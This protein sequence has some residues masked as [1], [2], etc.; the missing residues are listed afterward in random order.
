VDDGPL[1]LIKQGPADF[2]DVGSI[3]VE[4]PDLPANAAII[5]Y[6]AQL[7]DEHG[8]ASPLVQIDECIEISMPLP[9]PLLAP[10]EPAGTEAA[11]RMTVRWFCPPYG[12]DRF[13]VSIANTLGLLGAE[14]SPDL[15]TQLTNRVKQF[16]VNGTAKTN[17]FFLYRT[18]R[19]GPAFGNGAQF[20]ITVNIALGQKYTVMVAAVGQDGAV[21]DD[22]NAES[23]SWHVPPLVG[24]DVPWPARPLP[25][26]NFF[27]A[28]LQAFRMPDNIFPG[29]ALRI[30]DVPQ[31]R[32]ARAP[33]ERTDA[34]PALLR[35]HRDPLAY[36]YTN[37]LG[38]PL[39]PAVVYRVQ[40]A[41]AE[42]PQVSRDLNQ[43]TPLME[44]IAHEF[45]A[46]GQFGD[47]TVIHDP[48]IRVTEGVTLGG[49]ALPGALWLVDTQPVIA[50]ARYLYLIARL[51]PDGEILEVIP[52]NV[53]EATP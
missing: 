21:G 45:S 11:P 38:D 41:A 18:P 47:V 3:T 19:V 33:R 2:D 48:F 4:D 22:S 35:L 6:F 1:T 46:D 40:A 52:S 7:F 10:L 13:E 42:F 20:E 16:T 44:D 12:V 43:V 49:A 29:L 28:S 14:V 24:P 25:D 51:G 27:H 34:V 17:L 31:N 9:V 30:G 36:V 8:N 32:I 15:G 39:F 50:G 23:L 26:V 53:V 37:K 5:C